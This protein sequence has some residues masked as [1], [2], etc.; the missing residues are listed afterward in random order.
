[1][2]EAYERGGAAALSVL[3]EPHHFAGSLDDLREARRASGLPLLRKDFVLDPY[4]LYESA[5]AGADAV[6]LIVAALR[7]NDLER[8]HREA[9][10]L[11]LDVLVEVHDQPEL[12]SALEIDAALIGI[13]NRDLN[14]FSIDVERTYQL[15]SDVP[16]GKVVVS[17]S[18]YGWAWMPF[19]W[20]SRS[21]A[22]PTSR[23]RAGVSWAPTENRSPRRLGR[24]HGRPRH[25]CGCAHPS[26]G[27][28][29]LP[30]SSAAR[31]WPRSCSC[32]T[33]AR[34]PRPRR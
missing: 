2:V 30:L 28:P 17:E 25:S 13:N 5:A 16:A 20:A 14:D 15:L 3:T 6:L 27:S 4:Q 7:P 11:D 22:R 33:W 1:V 12:E 34:A 8:L 18:G 23:P 24:V 21:C 10:S 31:W 9:Q 32:S 26:F 19:W 29:C